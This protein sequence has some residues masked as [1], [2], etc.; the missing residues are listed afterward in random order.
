MQEAEVANY[1]NTMTLF[2]KEEE[3]EAEGQGVACS[4]S[5]CGISW[6]KMAI[7][8]PRASPR[9]CDMAEPI[10][11]P[12]VRLCRL[13]PTIITQARGLMF[14]IYFKGLHLLD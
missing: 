13:S 5:S 12:S 3:E 10:A 11:I 4:L 1:Y 9:L 7:A 8:V 14:L 2:L 6:N